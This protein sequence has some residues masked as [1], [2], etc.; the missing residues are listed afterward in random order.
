[1]SLNPKQFGKYAI[2]TEHIEDDI[3]ATG[4]EYKGSSVGQVT[5][6]VNPKVKKVAFTS[7]IEVSPNHRRKGIASALVRHIEESFPEH[8]IDPGEFTPEGSS[9][10]RNRK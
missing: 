9:F 10:W 8:T 7:N 3:W 5:Y 6:A 1:M 2:S 4:A